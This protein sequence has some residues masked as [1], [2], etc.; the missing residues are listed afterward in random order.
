MKRFTLAASL[1]FL[2]TDALQ[3]LAGSFDVKPPLPSVSGSV[4]NAQF[5][6]EQAVSFIRRCIVGSLSF[7][8]IDWRENISASRGCFSEAGW[9]EFGQTLD[10]SG[11]VDKIVAGLGRVTARLEGESQFQKDEDGVATLW[12]DTPIALVQSVG[13]DSGAGG[14]GDAIIQRLVV[15]VELTPTGVAGRDSVVI[16]RLVAKGQ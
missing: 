15:S 1:L 5:P 2:S 13:D 3:A 4:P 8:N 10:Q 9:R 7:S 12:L 16:N 14:E 11:V 6:G